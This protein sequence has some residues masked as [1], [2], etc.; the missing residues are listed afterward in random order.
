MARTNS[1]ITSIS[2]WRDLGCSWPRSVSAAIDLRSR[3]AWKLSDIA[4]P[5]LHPANRLD[6]GVSC[7]FWAASE[8]G[9]QYGLHQARRRPTL[10]RED[11]EAQLIAC[12]LPTDDATMAQFGF[13][14][15][16]DV[17]EIFDAGRDFERDAQ[18]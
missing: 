1:F 5:I 12:D 15:S 18:Q 4:T 11:V 17:D 16:A 7:D 13:S 10:T 2:N 9:R 8:E 14:G 3:I 6:N